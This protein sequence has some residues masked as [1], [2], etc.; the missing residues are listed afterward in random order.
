MKVIKIIHWELNL[1]RM[2]QT[3]L[4]FRLI[5]YHEILKFIDLDCN[6]PL[7]ND[8]FKDSLAKYLYDQ[9]CRGKSKGETK[10]QTNYSIIN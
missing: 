5:E 1:Y 8:E 6:D 4:T 10:Y 3:G 7:E 9:V 2:V